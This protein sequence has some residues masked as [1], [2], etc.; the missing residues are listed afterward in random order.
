VEARFED[1]DLALLADQDHARHDQGQLAEGRAVLDRAL[2]LGGRSQYVL[3]A[4]IAPRHAEEARD[5]RQIAALRR[6]AVPAHAVP[7]SSSTGPS[8]SPR[9]NVPEAGLE[10]LDGVGLEDFHYLH[11]SR[12]ELLRRLGRRAQAA[13]AHRCALE[14]V[15]HEAKRRLLEK[16]LQEL[17]LQ[18]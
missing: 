13:A 4:G 18:P 2:A 17:A 10:L 8:R 5:W 9:P 16:R 3:Q 14:P 12:A 15:H 11:A 6:R 1:G 7:S